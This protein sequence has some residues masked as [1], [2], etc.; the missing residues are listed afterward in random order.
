[1]KI[2]QA[3]RLHLYQRG[4]YDHLLGGLTDLQAFDQDELSHN[5]EEQEYQTQ[6]YDGKDSL[7]VF[8]RDKVSDKEDSYDEEEEGEMA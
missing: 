4:Y 5:D 1:M 3:Y 2:Q 6:I 8:A 7:E